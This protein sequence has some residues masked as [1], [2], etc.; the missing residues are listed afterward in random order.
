MI[1]STGQRPAILPWQAEP[2]RLW[3]LLEMLRH[4]AGNWLAVTSNLVR[5]RWLHTMAATSETAQEELEKHQV[6]MLGELRTEAIELPFSASL[7]KQ[8]DRTIKNLSAET[9]GKIHQVALVLIDEL[10]FNMQAEMD[11]HLY[12]CVP[13]SK[14]ALYVDAATAFGEQVESLF[15][16]ARK[17]V[18]EAARCLVLDRWTASVFHSMRVIE[19]GLLAIAVKVGL[20]EEDMKRENWKNIIDQIEKKI[21]EIEA[22]PKSSPLKG[23]TLRAL[24]V[25]ATQCRYIK[26]AWR[27]HVSHGGTAYGEVESE[28]VFNHARQFMQALAGV[29]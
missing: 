6:R 20:S 16:K 17:D 19:H 13:D 24:S 9:Y 3:S 2:H 12:L 7:K 26:D 15:P 27:N 28:T 10:I 23:E 14:K 8:I 29:V 1:P 18:F 21:R 5:L 4:Y 25:A 11:S 22:A